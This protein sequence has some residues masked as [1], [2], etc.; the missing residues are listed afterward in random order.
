MTT[1]A[2][3]VVVGVH[4][5]PSLQPHRIKSAINL[6]VAACSFAEL[7]ILRIGQSFIIT[8]SNFIVGKS[9][10]STLGQPGCISAKSKD[11][12]ACAY[13]VMHAKENR[14]CPAHCR[15]WMSALG[16]SIVN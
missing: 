16:S 8:T 2:G 1:P 9:G 4:I 5:L 7:P 6:S 10:Q 13:T 14:T 12:W 11:V 15:L 3:T